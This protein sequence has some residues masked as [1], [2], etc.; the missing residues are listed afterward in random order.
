MPGIFD[1]SIEETGYGFRPRYRDF[2]PLPGGPPGDR[3]YLATGHHRNGIR[4]TPGTPAH[5]IAL[6]LDGETPEV[7]MPNDPQQF[8][9]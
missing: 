7:L 4:W 6:M 3:L 9:L 2:A 5:G 8:G 1:L